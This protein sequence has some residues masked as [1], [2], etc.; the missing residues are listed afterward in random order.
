MPLVP[1]DVPPKPPRR[2]A[3]LPAQGNAL[4]NHVAIQTRSAQRAKGSPLGP[5]RRP[6]KLSTNG[7]GWPV[8]PKKNSRLWRM[9]PQGFTLGWENRGPSAQQYTAF[10][11]RKL[12]Y[13][14][15]WW[16]VASWQGAISWR[17]KMAARRPRLARG[18]LT[19][20]RQRAERASQASRVRLGEQARSLGGGEVFENAVPGGAPLPAVPSSAPARLPQ[21]TVRRCIT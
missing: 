13:G 15:R 7:N 8:G 4:G 1:Q 9:M 18:P 3:V 2:G 11:G 17:P 5:S 16:C 14:R 6:H 20:R 12:A 10:H 21:E 19:P